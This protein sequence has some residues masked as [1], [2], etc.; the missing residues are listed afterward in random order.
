[1]KSKVGIIC[2]ILGIL[3]LSGALVLHHVCA[4][5][6]LYLRVAFFLPA[7]LLIGADVL[8]EAFSHIFHGRVFDEA[9]LMTVATIGAFCIGEYPEAVFVMLFFQTSSN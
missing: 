3:L 5:A 9:F 6:P 1:M 2:I 7:Y 8:W 4:W